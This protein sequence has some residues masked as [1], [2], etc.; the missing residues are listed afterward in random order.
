MTA[1]SCCSPPTPTTRASTAKRSSA[2]TRRSVSRAVVTCLHGTAGPGFDFAPGFDLANYTPFTGNFPTA[3]VLLADGLASPLTKEF[4]LSAGPQFTQGLRAVLYTW[5][6][7]SELHR[8]LHRRPACRARSTVICD[9]VDFGTSTVSHY[10]NSNDVERKYQGCSSLDATTA[11]QSVLNGHYTLQFKNEG[12]FEGEAAN[13]PANPSDFGDWPPVLTPRSYPYGTLNDFQRSKLRLWAVYN[14]SL[15]W[16]GNV[17][18]GPI[19]RYNSAQTYSLFAS[20]VPLSCDPDRTV[21]AGGVC[22]AAGRRFQTL[23]F[24]DRGTE[25]FEGYGLVDI[26]AT[27]DIAIWRPSVRGSSSSCTTFSTTT[28]RSCGTRR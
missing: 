23:Y 10:R 11:G 19:W 12:N 27:Y 6:H 20:G 26:A 3:N 14:Q 18:V 21:A 24:D 16:A 7:A 17:T 22:Q 4:T 13:Q 15:G 5:R 28:S 1:G 2:A 25:S 8:G 9:G